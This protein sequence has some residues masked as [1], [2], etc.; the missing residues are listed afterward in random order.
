MAE[1]IDVVIA[2]LNAVGVKPSVSN[3]QDRLVV[4]KVVYLLQKLGVN[5]DFNYGLY[6]HGPY[7]PALTRCLFDNKPALEAGR[8]KYELTPKE[9]DAT[10]HLREIG[11][12]PALLEVMS[13]YLCLN[14]DLHEKED[15]A[16]R[17]LKELKPFI[18]EADVAVGISKAKQLTFKSTKEDMAWLKH[19][20][21]VL[22]E[23]SDET[24]R[25]LLKAG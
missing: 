10:N 18:S 4:Q 6:V 22:D 25:K 16:I 15:D 2:C 12:T 19:Q 24:A 9:V 17:R 21:K 11:F 13:T 20:N 7:S 8:T 5:L 23:A 14:T 1:K 3:F